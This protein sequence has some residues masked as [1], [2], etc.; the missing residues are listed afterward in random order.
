MFC[1]DQQQPRR[2]EQV[3]YDEVGV[4][5]KDAAFSWGFKK[6]A[7]QPIEEDKPV[8]SGL[9]LKLG[10][11]DMIVVVGKIGAGKTSLLFSLMDETFKTSGTSQV[12]GRLAYVE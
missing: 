5:L 11:A 4:D 1:L 9:D 2:L 12:R 3:V 10:P 7:A 6:N 8:I